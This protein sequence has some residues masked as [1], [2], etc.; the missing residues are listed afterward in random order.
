GGFQWAHVGGEEEPGMG[1]SIEEVAKKAGVSTATVSRALR[2]LSGVA[3][4]TRQRVLE[5]AAQLQY[6]AS[7]PA[8][9][10]AG[11]RTGAIGVV[12]PYV[13]RW[14]SAQIVSGAE[15]VLR[16][17]GL[18]LLL[19]NL[20]DEAGRV[21]IFDALRKRVDAVLVLGRPLTPTESEVLHTLD[22]PVVLVGATVPGF[23]SVRTDDVAGARAAVQHLINLGHRR[24]GLI[25][26]EGSDDGE[27]MHF[28][29]SQDRR[30]GYRQALAAAGIECD[31]GLESVGDFTWR[32]GT[33]AMA[34]LL[35]VQSPPTAVFAA[36]D[37]MAMGALEALRR[38]GF[39]VPEDMSVIGFGGHDMAELFGLTTIAQP[40]VR[41]GEIAARLLLDLLGRNRPSPSYRSEGAVAANVSGERVTGG[42]SAVGAGETQPPA[43]RLG[44]L[45][46]AALTA[47]P[48]QSES[49]VVEVPTRIQIRRTTCTGWSRLDIRP[50]LP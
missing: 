31:P 42:G 43:G 13:T 47:S 4:S 1:G 38:A 5:A 39:R 10:L 46:D 16:A 37:E 41:Q 49:I 2:G 30:H 48:D 17:E 50:R 27:P 14:F 40:V 9:R 45:T 20:G 26:G 15:A 12:V 33:R 24:I 7:P 19:Y 21:R 32:G 11:G 23:P 36:S 8:S 28:T 35:S 34:E 6:M 25:S 3:E 44:S 22:V 18:D 29:A